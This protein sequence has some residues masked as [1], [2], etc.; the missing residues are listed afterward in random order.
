MVAETHGE[1]PASAR[2]E[3]ELFVEFAERVEDW[4]VVVAL[5]GTGQEIHKGEEAGIGQWA[6]AIKN[7]SHGDDWE[8]HGPTAFADD[9]A[10]LRYVRN[11][12]L[13]LDQSLRSH[14]AFDVHKFVASLV[15]LTQLEPHR[16]TS[17]NATPSVA[18]EP[19]PAY[20][21]SPVTVTAEM[22]VLAKRIESDGHNL[23]I[24][25]DLEVAKAYLVERYKEDP[26]A[27]Y[28]IVASSRDKALGSFDIRN[29]FQ[30]TKRVKVGPWYGDNEDAPGQLSC[31]HFRECVTEFGSQGLELD[32]ALVA[33][34]TD[35]I[36]KDG[37]WDIGE[38]RG[39]RGGAKVIDPA[40]LRANAYRVLLTRARDC[41]VVFVPPLP[42]L[43]ET[44]AFLCDAGFADLALFM[45]IAHPM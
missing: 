36:R 22:Q 45:P 21:A 18:E 17:M 23:R 32:A 25:R 20:G 8:V 6:T 11:S 40:Q 4:C 44:Y 5:V 7:S 13:S 28:G 24:T 39:Y 37:V 27:R 3:P 34:G 35:F 42:I 19:R 9:F 30:S 15:S 12:A 1:D 10:G 33:W 43:D 31:R 29:D 2:S 38:A 16:V 41:S 14:L 26:L